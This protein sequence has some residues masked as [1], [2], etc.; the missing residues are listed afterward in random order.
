MKTIYSFTLDSDEY[1]STRRN[2]YNDLRLL[3]YMLYN[4]I[5]NYYGDEECP[6]DVN[7]L[8]EYNDLKEVREIFSLYKF[9][10]DN[11]DDGYTYYEPFIVGN[12]TFCFTVIDNN[13]DDR[14]INE[15]LEYMMNL[16]KLNYKI[17]INKYMYEARDIND[18]RYREDTVRKI[19]DK[20]GYK[21]PIKTGIFAMIMKY[22]TMKKRIRNYKRKN[23]GCY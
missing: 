19:Y 5:Y 22:K 3:A 13:F 20:H 21:C 23:Y 15:C 12:K 17:T 1:P 10:S 2:I 9:D 14:I 8:I 4:E 6:L 18:E 16:L 11:Y 7:P